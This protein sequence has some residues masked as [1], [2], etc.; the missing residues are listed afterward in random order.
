M[1][2]LQCLGP[3][4]ITLDTETR[5]R[6][7]TDRARALLVY[8]AMNGERPYRREELATLLWP[9]QS[10]SQ[11]RQNLR[12][13]L[14]RLRR[15]ASTLPLLQANSKDIVLNHAVVQ[16]DAQQFSQHLLQIEQHNDHTHLQQCPPCIAYLQEA[17]AL[18]QGAFLQGFYLDHSAPF[19]EWLLLTRENLQQQ[20]IHAFTILS[21]HY[22]QTGQDT[23]L[24]ETVQRLLAM[25]PWH[26]RAQ[27]QLLRALARTGQRAKAIAHYEAY[28]AQLEQELGIAPESETLQLYRQLQQA[29]IPSQATAVWHGFP[30]EVTSFVGRS[31]ELAQITTQI[32]APN[33]R[34]LTLTGSGGMGKTRLAVQAA[35][36]VTAVTFPDG[37]FFIPLAQLTHAGQIVP[38]I[39]AQIGLNFAGTA[40]PMRQL[41]EYLQGR[42]MLLL[43]DNFEHLMDGASL[44]AE[45]LQK[46]PGLTCLVTSRHALNLQGE[47]RLN[48]RGLDELEESVTLF[49]LRA[50]RYG[51]SQFAETDKILVRQIAYL[52]QGMPLALEMAAAW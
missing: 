20:A 7:A 27:R 46:A 52:V 5:P 17:L 38:Q 29:E 35:L 16:C 8:L 14:S 26:E 25:E 36:Q 30:A 18:Y 42:Q 45:L 50:Q 44:V 49:M 15:A 33:C 24:I 22:E 32:T 2:Y 43:L 10:N 28:A 48:L 39:A 41:Q 40:P 1:L 11:A 3:L 47:W 21:S 51:L 23:Q 34:L 9:E 6:F 31:Q 12:K 19:E 4:A 37:L 13:T